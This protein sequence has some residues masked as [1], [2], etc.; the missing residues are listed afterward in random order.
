MLLLTSLVAAAGVALVLFAALGP[1]QQVAKTDAIQDRVAF[2]GI[3]SAPTEEDELARLSFFERMVQPQL[4]RL[5]GLFERITSVDYLEEVQRDLASA[6][7]PSGLTPAVYL[8][9][10]V[11]FALVGG[12][13]GIAIGLFLGSLQAILVAT[14]IGAVAAW[15]GIGWWLRGAIAAERRK[16]RNALPDVIDFLVVAVD[17]GLGFDTALNRVV[18]RH[19][20]PLTAGFERALAEVQLGKARLEALEDFGKRTQVPE[21]AA[22]VAMVVSSERLGVPIGQALRIQ[23]Q[24]IRWRRSEWAR[25]E[26]SRAPVRMTIPM[27]LLVFPTL[28]LILL[29]PSLIKLFTT[30]L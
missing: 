11:A 30:G 10:R 3:G 29:G 14:A 9:L 21:V 5:Q 25:E 7:N 16:L 8:T 6:G 19:R 13:F 26:A 27:V 20:N 24:D 2:Y 15:I 12:G 4:N 18:T 28:W 1:N 22:F 17:A 23:A